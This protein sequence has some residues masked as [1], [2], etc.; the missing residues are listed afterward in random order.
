MEFRNN[1]RKLVRSD[2]KFLK[3]DY[4]EADLKGKFQEAYNDTK[5]R[6]L[7]PT[8]INNLNDF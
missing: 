1:H 2:D 4:M 8:G 7:A 3:N 5:G 6:L